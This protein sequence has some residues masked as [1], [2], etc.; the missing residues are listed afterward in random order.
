MY[1]ESI[2]NLVKEDNYSIIKY[3]ITLSS[4]LISNYDVDP[5]KLCEK[6]NFKFHRLLM[7]WN[8]LSHG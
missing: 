7:H 4:T 8:L 2:N 5:A 1:R 3:L 6:F